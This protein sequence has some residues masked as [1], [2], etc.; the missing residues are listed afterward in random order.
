[1]SLQHVPTYSSAKG[2]VFISAKGKVFVSSSRQAYWSGLTFPSPGDLP[3][4]GI[5][6]RS[7]TLQ[8]DGLPSEPP[9][10]PT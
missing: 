7:P 8:T 1:M 6:P 10:K 2:K 9:G 3:D 4:L 5:E